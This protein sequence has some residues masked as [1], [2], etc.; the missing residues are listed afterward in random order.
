MLPEF[1]NAPLTDFSK[2][3]NRQAMTAAI[4]KVEAQLG[5]EYPL[6]IGGQEI[7]TDDKIKSLNPSKFSEVVGFFSKGSAAQAEQAIAVADETFKMWSRIPGEERA[8]YLIKA[9]AIMKRRRLELAAYA[10]EKG[11]I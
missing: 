4:E 11:L 6:L 9:A 10:G 8:R 3:D 5:R 7:K 1:V 2:D